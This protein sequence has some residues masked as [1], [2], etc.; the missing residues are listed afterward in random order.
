MKKRQ[1]FTLIELLAVIVILAIIALI[2]VPVVMNIINRAQK[3]AFKDS[4]YGIVKA[5]ELYYT[6]Q[7]LEPTGMT[8]DKIF[9]FPS[10]TELEIKGSKPTGG[11]MKV[12]KDGKVEMAITNGRYCVTKGIN[13]D[14]VTIKEDDGNCVPK[15]TEKQLSDLATTYTFTSLDGTT[16]ASA[17]TVPACATSGTCEAGTPFA[18]KVN[19]TETYK[20][21]VL[22]DT[23]TK[24]TLIMDRNIAG[25]NH[26]IDSEDYAEANQDDGTVCETWACTDEG[27]ITALK[28]V[29]S[30]TSDWTNIP[31]MTYT[32][33]DDYNNPPYYSALTRTD[34]R[35]RIIS[36]TEVDEIIAENNGTMPEWLYSN[37]GSYWT[38]S[39]N[40]TKPHQSWT[41]LNDGRT[42]S[43]TVGAN[44]IVRVRPVIV[45]N[46]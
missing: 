32:L 16:D 8:E 30:E 1:G 35:A 28:T 19:D 2:A 6:N 25:C 12:T 23:G 33:T 36:M 31:L 29:E 7:L 4:A 21:Y 41:V 14:D 39:P 18:I 24:V 17:T 3:S 44:V 45:L 13:D 42:N 38:S 15:V 34:V 26:W 20:F 5:G 43:T 11:S 22:S 46:K 37:S 9:K 27:P 10:D 40:S